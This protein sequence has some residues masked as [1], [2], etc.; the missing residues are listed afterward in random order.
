MFKFHC[1]NILKYD[2]G[3]LKATKFEHSLQH[4]DGK[5]KQILLLTAVGTYNT[6][7]RKIILKMH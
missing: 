5:G 3:Q 2:L 7:D 6:K 1:F 4:F